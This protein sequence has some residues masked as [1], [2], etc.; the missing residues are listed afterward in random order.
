MFWIASVNW[1][2]RPDTAPRSLIVTLPLLPVTVGAVVILAPDKSVWLAP[3]P[4]IK[5]LPPDARNW[6]AASPAACGLLEEELSEPNAP[7]LFLCELPDH[8]TDQ[9]NAHDQADNEQQSFGTA[10]A[11]RGRALVRDVAAGSVDR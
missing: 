1:L 3:A 8:K 9:G 6:F 4:R 7:I 5:F 2:A 11:G 10:G